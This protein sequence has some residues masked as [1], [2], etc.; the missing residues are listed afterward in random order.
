MVCLR[1][2]I[3]KPTQ[4]PELPPF[5]L[6][7]WHFI[8]AEEKKKS[9]YFSLLLVDQPPLGPITGIYNKNCYSIYSPICGG[10]ARRVTGRPGAPAPGSDLPPQGTELP[11]TDLSRCVGGSRVVG[12]VLTTEFSALGIKQHDWLFSLLSGVIPWPSA[13]KTTQR[14]LFVATRNGGG[15]EATNADAESCLL[16][17]LM[18]PIFMLLRVNEFYTEMENG[19]LHCFASLGP[20]N[21][22]TWG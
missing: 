3:T 6:L 17:L 14:G 2:V 8:L 10:E 15:C 19:S 13:L 12:C 21:I 1:P 4:K 22:T 20:L 18:M 7:I 16:L 9:I 5:E 11:C